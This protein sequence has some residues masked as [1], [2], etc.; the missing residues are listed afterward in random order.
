VLQV[1]PQRREGLDRFR[2]GNDVELAA[3]RNQQ[4]CPH[5]GF[6]VPGLAGGR[7]SRTFGYEA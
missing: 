5:E 7:A 6:E 4:V 1:R 2:L 3:A